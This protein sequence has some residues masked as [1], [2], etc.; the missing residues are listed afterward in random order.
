M[1][2][3]AEHG[4]DVSE[5]LSMLVLGIAN[6][7]THS[8]HLCSAAPNMHWIFRGCFQ[9]Y[10]QGPANP[11]FTLNSWQTVSGMLNILK[12]LSYKYRLSLPYVIHHHVDDSL[13]YMMYILLFRVVA[14][15][16]LDRPDCCCWL[17]YF[18]FGAIGGCTL[19]YLS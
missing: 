8:E 18:W 11:L 16:P 10:I 5:V 12:F 14:Y 13:S 1:F 9:D 6:Y 3:S 7:P 2:G 17:I 4:L 19:L 15:P